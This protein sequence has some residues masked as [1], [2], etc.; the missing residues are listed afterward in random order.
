MENSI[1][2]NPYY[3]AAREYIAANDLT[4]LAAGRHEIDGDNLYVNIIDGELRPVEQARL[5]VHDRYIDVQVPLSGTESFGVR[6][7]NECL[8]PDGDMDREND[9]MFYKDPI[10][11]IINVKAGEV[12]VFP[13]DTAHAPL[14]GEGG[15]HKAVFKVR[16][17]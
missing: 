11:T 1:E 8:L 6:P 16:V 10:E 17:C 14:I 4:V 5:E 3:R 9:I 13:P 7:R 12:I 2:N 15:I